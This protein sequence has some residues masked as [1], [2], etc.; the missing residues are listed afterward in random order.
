MRRLGLWGA[1]LAALLATVGTAA[2]AEPYGLRGTVVGLEDD[3]LT[4]MNEDEET[5]EVRITEDTGRFAVTPA[6]WSDIEAGQFVGITSI[7]T[8]GQ[9]V[10]LEVHI[11][12]EDL[13]GVGEGHYPW[14][15]VKDPNMMT[16]AT[17]AEIEEVNPAQRQLRL[18]YQEGEGESATAGEQIIV[19]PD[20]VDVVLLAKGEDPA[21]IAPDRR[22]FLLVQDAEEGPP[23][24]LAVAVGLEGV[25]PPM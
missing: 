2:P 24:A 10:A 12:A 3:I 22:A 9:R 18:T 20:F 25:T 17:V 11:F 6:K 4:V 19:V 13:R 23:T 16:N 7:E 5:F 15:L 8:G 14:D 1:A 21:L